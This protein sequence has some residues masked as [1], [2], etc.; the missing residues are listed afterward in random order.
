MKRLVGV[1]SS[2]LSSFD[3]N[4]E[5]KELRIRF[6][7]SDAVYVYMGVPFAVGR[8]F[9]TAESKGS[10]LAKSIKPKYKVK[11][12]ENVPVGKLEEVPA[13]NLPREEVKSAAAS[14]LAKAK[15]LSKG[16]TRRWR[17]WIWMACGRPNTQALPPLP[18]QCILYRQCV[19][20]MEQTGNS[21]D[22]AVEVANKQQ[23]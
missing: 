11:K 7:S 6:K 18:T 19:A 21:F 15:A 12:V 5:L 10:F 2:N 22:K 16:D 8:Q 4:E 13:G 23:A 1:E 14:T 9:M 3:Y 17:Y 20:L